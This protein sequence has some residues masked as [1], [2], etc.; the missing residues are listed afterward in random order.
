[1]GLELVR[2]WVIFA[3]PP[4]YSPLGLGCGVTAFDVADA[5]RLMHRC[6]PE[7]SGLAVKSVT[8]NVSVSDLDPC[9]ILPNMGNAAARGVWFPLS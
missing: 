2:Y 9:H 7:T 1:M 4:K 3:S 8:E 5:M 6:F